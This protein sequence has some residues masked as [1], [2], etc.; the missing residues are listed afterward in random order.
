MR[1]EDIRLRDGQIHA[2]VSLPEEKGPHP[3]VIVSH[4]F[5]GHRKERH[6]EGV[7]DALN[8]VGFATVRADF[9]NNV[10]D[11][12]GE[13]SDVTVTQELTD[14]RVIF[15]VMSSR[16]D[17]DPQRIGATGHSLGGLVTGTFAAE[18]TG[19]KSVALLSP[20]F[21]IDSA[22]QNVFGEGYK[23]WEQNVTAPVY[24]KSR[25]QSFD[26]NY[27][28]LKDARTYDPAKSARELRQPLLV[29]E[30]NADTT[31][32]DSKRWFDEAISSKKTHLVTVSGANHTYGEDAHLKKVVEETVLWFKETL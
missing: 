12:A 8:K 24:S 11:S 14:L 17:M 13:F 28:F 6:I 10:G 27:A 1:T 4:G 22:M 20:V 31:V 29:V 16:E 3:L 18:E 7:S 5:K 19:I 2:T 23:T 21:D 26:I 9:T 15:D 32:Q 30:G 25:Q